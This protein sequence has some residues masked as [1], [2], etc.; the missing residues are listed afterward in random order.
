M[1]Q[2]N[3]FWKK[4]TKPFFKISQDLFLYSH[5]DH[6]YSLLYGSERKS[7]MPLMAGVMSARSKENGVYV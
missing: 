2:V 7:R 4:N 3:L 5:V 6:I 1:T